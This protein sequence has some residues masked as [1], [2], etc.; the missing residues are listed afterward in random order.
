MAKR[1]KAS[2][3]FEDGISLR[4]IEPGRLYSARVRME[5]DAHMGG[6]HEK[7][8]WSKS[9]QIKASSKAFRRIDEDT[10]TEFIAWLFEQELNG[11]VVALWLGMT[12]HIRLG[13]A[14]ALRAC[15][16]DFDNDAIYI[17]GTLDKHGKIVPAKAGSERALAMGSFLKGLLLAW[18]DTQKAE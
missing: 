3:Y 10:A 4:A 7:W 8:Y 5:P 15:D 2:T 18:I 13:E 1:K 17:R 6:P 12:E 14:L 16:L 11:R 9:K